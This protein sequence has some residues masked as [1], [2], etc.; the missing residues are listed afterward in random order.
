MRESADEHHTAEQ[1]SKTGRWKLPKYLKMSEH[2]WNIAMQVI[3]M[4]TLQVS[5]QQLWKQNEGAFQR[6]S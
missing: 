1:Y 5:E 6:S 2:T 3:F 4:I